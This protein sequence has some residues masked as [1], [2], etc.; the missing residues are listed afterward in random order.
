M[1]FGCSIG[2]IIAVLQLA[3]TVRERFLIMDEIYRQSPR[4]YGVKSI[5]LCQASSQ[6][7]Q[8]TTKY[9]Q[10]YTALSNI[11]EFNPIPELTVGKEDFPIFSM[12]G[13]LELRLL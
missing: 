12:V 1:S 3:N 4:A 2:G 13:L 7:A 11:L 9:Q 8:Q 5:L 10:N 6:K